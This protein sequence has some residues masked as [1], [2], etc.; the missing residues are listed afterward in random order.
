MNYVIFTIPFLLGLLLITSPIL[1]FAA[2]QD[3]KLTFRGAHSSVTFGEKITFSGS[4]RDGLGYALPFEKITIWDKDGLDYEFI[5]STRTD[6]RGDYKVSVTAKYWDGKGDPVETLAYFDGNGFNRS[7]QTKIFKLNIDEPR[8]D[9]YYDKQ[10]RTRTI[11]S[12]K[13][14]VLS[15][16]VMEGSGSKTL[17]VY[18][19][20]SDYAGNTIS[21]S[22]LSVYVNNQYKGSV[23]SNQWSHSISCNS[24]SNHV[25]VSTGNFM[26]GVIVYSGSSDS[27]YFTCKSSPTSHSS[28]TTS[29]RNIDTDGDGIV[30]KY[31]KCD[32]QKETR[33]GYQDSDG[34]PDTKPTSKPV[35]TEHQKQILT[36]K[37]DAVSVSMLKLKEGMDV[38]WKALKEADKKYTDSQSKTHVKKAWDI[39]NRLYNDR[40]NSNN[41]LDSIVQNYF[42]LEDSTTTGSGHF[43]DFTSKLSKID[44]EI[45]RIGSDTKY[46]SQELDYAQ[47]ASEKTSQNQCNW[48]WC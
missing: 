16:E 24:G 3:S 21:H 47:K 41:L 17:R 32:H 19:K 8:K 7:V 45:L 22:K 18:P 36:K 6:A 48:F 20:L 35:F 1:V 26:Q 11:T 33:N 2:E 15:L 46:I 5:T 12:D 43:N 25:S 40:Y 31:D 29:T 34:C 37:I 10:E 14:S 39:Y 44:S 4:L 28:S 42:K 30:D 27:E 13:A 38:S 23:S 9:T